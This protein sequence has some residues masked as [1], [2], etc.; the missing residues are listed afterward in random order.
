MPHIIWTYQMRRS[1]CVIWRI[2]KSSLSI[3][4]SF[5][6]KFSTQNRC[7][8]LDVIIERARFKIT[9][10][11]NICSDLIKTVREVL[12]D[13]ILFVDGTCCCMRRSLI[14]KSCLVDRSM[15][16]HNCIFGRLHQQISQKYNFVDYNLDS[17]LVSQNQKWSSEG[18]SRCSCMSHIVTDNDSQV[19]HVTW[20]M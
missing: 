8:T 4:W 17:F 13:I 10:V 2:A 12:W 1:L 16:E 15:L 19:T 18:L 7:C 5:V 6:G 14:I 11:L 9:A 3:W 20:V